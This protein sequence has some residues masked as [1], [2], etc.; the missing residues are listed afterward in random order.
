[1]SRKTAHPNLSEMSVLDLHHQEGVYSVYTVALD[2]QSGKIL[3]QKQP[4]S[5]NQLNIAP[6]H[7]VLQSLLMKAPTETFSVSQ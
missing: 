4:N 5:T 2:N 3:R 1:M 7:K 6:G